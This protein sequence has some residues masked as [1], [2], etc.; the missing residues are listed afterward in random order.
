MRIF[1]CPPPTTANRSSAMACVDSRVAMCVNSV[2]RVTY[3][4]PLAP[5][6]AGAN[7]GTGPEAL[8]KLAIKPKGRRQFRLPS[9]VSLPTES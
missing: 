1:T 9:Q 7:G 2:P 6:I 3:S 8:P 4:E 5:R